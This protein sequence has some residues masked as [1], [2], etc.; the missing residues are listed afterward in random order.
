[1]PDNNFSDKYKAM[2][3]VAHDPVFIKGQFDEAVRLIIQRTAEVLNCDRV[4]AWD[5]KIIGNEKYIR[6]IELWV[7]STKEFSS[8]TELGED[9][10]YAYLNALERDV[11]LAMHDVE[12]DSRC[13]ELMQEYL[14]AHNIKSML[15]APFLYDGQ[16]AGVLCAEHVGEKREWS[17]EEQHFSANMA[18]LLSI[19]RERQHSKQ[20]E[21]LLEKE[22]DRYQQLAYSSRE[23]IMVTVDNKIE[24]I[25]PTLKQLAA[26]AN[27]N[28]VDVAGKNVTDVLPDKQAKIALERTLKI[29]VNKATL[30]PKEYE[31]PQSDGSVLYFEVSSKYVQWNG[32]DAIQSSIRNVT[33]TV[34]YRKTLERYTTHLRSL[35]NSFP[36][37]FT[38][39]DQN[40][41]FQNAND[42]YASWFGV[43]KE[44]II[45]K[46]FKSFVGKKRY[47]QV[48]PQLVTLRAGKSIT[49]EGNLTEKGDNRPVQFTVVP[50]MDEEGKM[51]GF[52]TLITDLTDLKE[53]EKALRQ[54]QKMEAVGQLSGG[55]AHD[56]NNL[57][58]VIIGNLELMQLD[59]PEDSPLESNLENAMVAARRGA[60]LTLKLLGFS[61]QSSS[62]S[63]IISINESI[64]TL[65]SLINKSLTASITVELKLQEDIWP[66]M[67]NSGELSDSILNIAINARD[68]ME[69]SNGTLTIT[70]ENRKVHGKDYAVL[71][72]RDTGSGIEESQ[73]DFI[74]N[75]FY[76]T[77]EESK[78]SGLGLS[79]VYGFVNRSGGIIEVDSKVGKGTEFRLFFPRLQESE[80]DRLI[81]DPK[82]SH[83]PKLLF[84]S[85]TI[86]IVDDEEPLLSTI[87]SMLKKMGYKTHTADNPDAALEILKE[88]PDIDLLFSDIVLGT[89]M[90][91][92]QLAMKARKSNSKLKVLLTTG[93]NK[94]EWATEYSKQLPHSSILK[95]PY[96]MEDLALAIQDALTGKA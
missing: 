9:D 39:I 91:G 96:K 57:L 89:E 81:S 67:L 19:A 77:K 23:G 45:G 94:S 70:T 78:G 25:N 36:G 83:Q 4:S 88:H 22:K 3:A 28:I 24:F 13:V 59:I 50:D 84:G 48:Q 1:M 55:I 71:T 65:L 44:N 11:V 43:D 34:N 92:Y 14:P 63:E 54:A 66:I 10:C 85:E 37:G 51:Q 2:S 7:R 72:M 61:R 18:S 8:G 42:V 41:I 64:N 80:I 15:D 58:S 73:L 86:L 87:D 76:T 38:Y 20:L 56:F 40:E 27:L 79:M 82:S 26:E 95:K 5:Y 69:E 60:D 16:L 46:S 29:L 68:A 21:R 75:P 47:E 6:C 12:T 62:E 30:E 52:F 53:T 49:Y 32:Q 33:S 35:A 93:F 74:F 90:D 17:M 31:F